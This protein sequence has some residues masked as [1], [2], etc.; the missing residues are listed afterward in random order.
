LKARTDRFLSTSPARLQEFGANEGHNSKAQLDS[1][2]CVRSLA[3]ACAF[4]SDQMDITTQAPRDRH[5]SSQ[6]AHQAIA[7]SALPAA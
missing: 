2:E 7:K 5:Y 4:A 1:T 3:F 6:H